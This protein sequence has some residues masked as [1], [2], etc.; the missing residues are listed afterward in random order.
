MSLLKTKID[1]YAMDSKTGAI[2]S[3][4]NDAL[5][6]YKKK[7]AKRTAEVVSVRAEARTVAQTS[8]RL[9]DLEGDVAEI[10]AMLSA[11]INSLKEHK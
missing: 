1:G 8:E 5:R 7:R 4:D 9:T 3:V 11:L 2:L 6:V 10:K